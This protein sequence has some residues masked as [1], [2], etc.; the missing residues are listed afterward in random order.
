MAVV[1][2][3]APKKAATV[4]VYLLDRLH[5]LGV[6]HIFGLPGDYI[7]RFDKLIEEHP[8]QFINSTREN[9]AG[10]MA[11]AYAR[12]HGLGVA[13]IT[14]GVGINITNAISQAYME[15]SPVVLISGAAGPGELE[16]CPHL[17]HLLN[18][19][20]TSHPGTTQLEIF[21]HITVD[22]AV[23]NDPQTAPQQIDRVLD[24]CICYKKPVYIEL[25]RDQ[26]DARIP[27]HQHQVLKHPHSDPETLQEAMSEVANILKKCERPVIWVGHEVQRFGLTPQL[28][29]FAEKYR[30][31]I[32]STLLGK[33]T[34]S[35]RHPLFAGV[36]QGGMSREEIQEF[37]ETCDC[38]L[39]IGVILNDV[40]TGMFTSKL[41][42][43][44]KIIA[45][46]ETIN[47]SHHHYHEIFFPEFLHALSNL[48]LNVR[49][50]IDYP[51][52]VDRDIG[53]FIPQKGK[54]ITAARTFDCIQNHLKPDHI[55]VSDIGDCL[56]GSSD[57]ILEQNCYI[58]NA[59]FSSLG[60]GTPGAIGA[61]I[62]SPKKRVIGIVGDGAFQMTSM[63][64]AT[65]VRYNLNPVIIVL[66]NHGYGTERPLLEGEYNDILD[67]NYTDIPKVL[68]G[69]KGVKVKTEDELDKALTQ[70]LGKR[71][72]FTIIEVEL[73]KTDF[74]PALH[75][76]CE[77]V[78][79]K[80]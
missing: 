79:N 24:G 40:D 49:Y 8:I 20:S 26:V 66:N 9:T 50:R 67:W 53:T 10:Y 22:Q 5:E 60:F 74:S 4:G 47:I 72:T 42:Q 71:E 2:K 15:S 48:D 34:I 36:Y 18:K 64:L 43:E 51:A 6:E 59:Y 41:E 12:L 68:G 46:T 21:K 7:L 77:L 52:T 30:I 44:Q 32:V 55:V 75:R 70:A 33:T 37:V 29:K 54:K 65:A 17:H 69:G 76:F 25:P 38:A 63:E 13:C 28:L 35:E 19:A 62:A 14:Y 27:A 39:L 78:K 23:L 80:K 45:N 56:F 3:R 31:P 16:K 1:I 73:G 61:Q 58:S 11:D 57:F